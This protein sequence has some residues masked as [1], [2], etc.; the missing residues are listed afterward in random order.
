MKKILFFTFLFFL[1]FPHSNNSNSLYIFQ[2]NLENTYH[3][4]ININKEIDN[5]YPNFIVNNNLTEKEIYNSL[6]I[7]SHIL[8]NFNADFFQDFYKYN[9]QGLNI[10]LVSNIIPNSK[11]LNVSA[12]SLDYQKKYSIVIN[13]TKKPLAKIL[14]HEL[15]HIMEYNIQKEAEP[16]P[17]WESYNPSN[18]YYNYS[19]SSNYNFNYTLTDKLENIYF[20]DYYAHSYPEEDRA[21]I[22]ENICA[23]Q[24]KYSYYP[25]INN[26][27][28]YLKEELLKYYPSLL[29]S[30]LF[31]NLTI[32]S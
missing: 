12:F 31:E 16:F 8:A 25:N 13:V 20:L 21:R 1:I 10:N 14:C 17:N 30:K 18:F 3:L 19:Y 28:L 27:A 22:F 11:D 15:M 24:A 29:K 4:K 9:Y 5:N 32:T 7:I 2:N 23:Y 26:K 6:I